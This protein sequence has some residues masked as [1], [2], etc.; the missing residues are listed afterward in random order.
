MVSATDKVS[1]VFFT[2]TSLDEK[3]SNAGA[4]LFFRFEKYVRQLHTMVMSMT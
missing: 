4:E 2:A 1:H 3:L